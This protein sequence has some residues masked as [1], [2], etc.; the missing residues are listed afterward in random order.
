MD[1]MND[2]DKAIH[3]I[4]VTWFHWGIHGWIPYTVVGALMGIMSYRRDMPLTMRF[5][6][7]PLIGEQVYG[8]MGGALGLPAPNP[9]PPRTRNVS[10]RNQ[11]PRYPSP[12]HA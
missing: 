2:N 6:L 5:C 7:Y 10:R 11:H 8:W 1:N 9:P 12:T 3:A 4:M